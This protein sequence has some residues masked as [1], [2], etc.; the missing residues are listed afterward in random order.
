MTLLRSMPCTASDT[1][2]GRS[3]CRRAR[4]QTQAELRDRESELMA[5]HHQIEEAIARRQ[6]AERRRQCRQI[7]CGS[8]GRRTP[9]GRRGNAH[10]AHRGMGV[11]GGRTGVVTA[12]MVRG[13][14]RF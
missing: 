1:I 3:L 10:G 5:R 13:L 14:S 11:G 4:E 2:T 8:A 9:T 7:R 12:D 6:E